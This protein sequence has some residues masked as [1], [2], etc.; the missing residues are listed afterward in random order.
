M[1][2]GDGKERTSTYAPQ[3]IEAVRWCEAKEMS[4]LVQSSNAD[5]DDLPL[6]S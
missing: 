5:D 1:D 2:D 6:P 3:I 4:V